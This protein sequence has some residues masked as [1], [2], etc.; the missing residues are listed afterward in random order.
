MNVKQMR[1]L[2][3]QSEK[4]DLPLNEKYNFYEVCVKGKI[5]LLPH[6]P[7]KEI[8][9]KQKLELDVCGPMQTQ[10]HGRSHYFK[11]QKM[12]LTS[13]SRLYELTEV[14]NIFQKNSSTTCSNMESD[15]NQLQ[16]ILHNKTVWQNN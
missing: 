3:E 10:S 4:L 12:S 8:K 1:Q 16:L 7:L 14:E 9:S 6:P 5:H 13:K 2:T 11:Q 15:V